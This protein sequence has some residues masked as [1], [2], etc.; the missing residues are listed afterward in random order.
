MSDSVTKEVPTAISLDLTNEDRQ[1]ALLVCRKLID[2][3]GVQARYSLIKLEEKL[4]YDPE[5]V[6]KATNP[7]Q[8]FVEWTQKGRP[9]I[10]LDDKSQKSLVEEIDRINRELIKLS[11]EIKEKVEFRPLR[12]SQFSS[13][14][15]PA[16]VTIVIGQNND[17]SPREI[18]ANW[19][20]SLRD[21]FFDDIGIE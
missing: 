1:F 9:K 7:N 15:T 20:S 16:V 18:T 5:S 21:F 11:R 3:V 6:L 17:G 14:T 4:K 12:L 2:Y 13:D 10:D 8:E 19:L